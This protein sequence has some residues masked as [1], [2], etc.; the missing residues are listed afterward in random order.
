MFSVKSD[1]IENLSLGWWR[2]EHKSEERQTREI[3]C[4]MGKKFETRMSMWMMLERVCKTD[5]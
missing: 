2:K 3:V 1:S 5:M 4:D